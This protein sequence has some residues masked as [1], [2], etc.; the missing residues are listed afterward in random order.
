[1]VVVDEED[2]MERGMKKL[3]E[4]YAFTR[5][6]IEET[7]RRPI[8]AVL[9]EARDLPH[10]VKESLAHQLVDMI[11]DEL[12]LSFAQVLGICESIKFIRF[13]AV[14]RFM[15]R[16]ERELMEYLAEREAEEGSE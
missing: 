13:V 7:E 4:A 9:R 14:Q 5:K 1:V 8:W 16:H 10:Y 6:L 3:Y 12:G 2:E 15:R 11:F